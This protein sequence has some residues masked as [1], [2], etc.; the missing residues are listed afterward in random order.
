M[1]ARL[2]RSQTGRNWIA[3]RDNE[4]A[5]TVIG[6]PVFRTKLLAFA[7][8]SFYCGVAG[9]LWAFAYLRTVEPDGFSLDLS[10]KILFIIIIGG[11]ASIR[12]AFFG[13]AFIVVFPLLLSR[14][15]ASVFG[16]TDSGVVEM[17]E[18]M[19]VGLLII[20]TLIAEPK[21]SPP[22]GTAASHFTRL[23]QRKC[24]QHESFHHRAAP[25]HA[26]VAGRRTARD[27]GEFRRPSAAPTINKSLPHPSPSNRQYSRCRAIASARMPPTAPDSSAGSSTT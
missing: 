17:V 15:G 3:V 10:F 4:L 14:V 24:P 16:S 21:G 19:I 22:C 13:A 27:V 5:A 9:V 12:G 20:V 2:V 8:S 7:I 26:G 11:L 1:R 23:P 6:V 18:T 25:A